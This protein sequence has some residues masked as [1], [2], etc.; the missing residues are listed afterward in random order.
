MTTT[1]YTEEWG[2]SLCD[3]V[4]LLKRALLTQG[5][6]VDVVTPGNSAEWHQKATRDGVNSLIGD[7]NKNAGMPNDLFRGENSNR[8]AAAKFLLMSIVRG[9]QEDTLVALLSQALGNNGAVRNLP[10]DF[11]SE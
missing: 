4:W 7:L 10:V 3:P 1:H 9:G 11:V 6:R 5:T 2:Q 8:A